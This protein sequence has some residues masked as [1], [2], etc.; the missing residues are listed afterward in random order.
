M[1]GYVLPMGPAPS[2]QAQ[3]SGAEMG[4]DPGLGRRQLP[5]FLQGRPSPPTLTLGPSPHL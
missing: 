5:L 3:Q 1:G 4:K 2:V